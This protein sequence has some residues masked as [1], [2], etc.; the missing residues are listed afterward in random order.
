MN[1]WKPYFA[2]FALAASAA[3]FSPTPAVPTSTVSKVDVPL[4][5]ITLAGLY[6]SSQ[7]AFTFLQEHPEVMFIETRDPL[8]VSQTGHPVGIDAIVPIRVHSDQFLE[9]QGEYALLPNPEFLDMWKQTVADHGLS[10]SSVVIVTCGNGRRSALAVDALTEAGYTNVWHVVDG[11][12]GEKLE[13]PFG[14]NT[15]NAWR[16]AGLPWTDVVIVPGSE[17][18]RLIE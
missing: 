2:A 1:N 13:H 12:K 17:L 6:L 4:E 5:K 15:D 8:E 10:K 18:I 14:R 3:W 16:I 11:Y 9:D 7:D